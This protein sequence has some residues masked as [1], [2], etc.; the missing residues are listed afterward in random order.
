MV[1]SIL[2]TSH[3]DKTWYHRIWSNWDLISLNDIEHLSNQ[4]KF[5]WKTLYN[6]MS[7]WP[8]KVTLQVTFSKKKNSKISLNC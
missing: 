3:F 7:P 2:T 4:S 6:G 5:I 8:N 1:G